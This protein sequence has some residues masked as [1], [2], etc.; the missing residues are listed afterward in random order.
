[1]EGFRNLIPD[2]ITAMLE[3]SG[4][5]P[6]GTTI[7]MPDKYTILARR[8]ANVYAFEDLEPEVVGQTQGG[9]AVEFVSSDKAL[10]F[11]T[12]LDF[13]AERLIFDPVQGIGFLQN[14]S[15]TDR[16]EIEIRILEFQRSILG[17]G[18]LEIWDPES[19]R[20]LGRSETCIPVNC[21]INSE[22]YEKELA[23]LREL[24]RSLSA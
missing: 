15:D 22:F 13:S 2:E 19:D 24:A 12:V 1:M 18:H 5:V 10:R 7:E 23:S 4:P 11:R 14:R 20:M 3:E 6:E 17:N 8:G 9:M 21:F 16:V